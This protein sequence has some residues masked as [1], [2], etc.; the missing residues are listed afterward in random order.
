MN[1]LKLQPKQ[2]NKDILSVEI[3]KCEVVEKKMRNKAYNFLS[4]IGRESLSEVRYEDRCAYEMYLKNTGVKTK[5]QEYMCAFDKVIINSKKAKAVKALGK[6]VL[7]L[8]ERKLFLLYDLPYDKALV[9]NKTID[10]TELLWDFSFRC[11]RKIKKQIIAL[12]NYILEDYDSH[13][14]Q[15]AYLLSL[16]SLYR[17]CYEQKINDLLKLE[18]AEERRFYMY[19]SSDDTVPRYTHKIIDYCRKKLFLHSEEISWTACVWYVERFK[20]DISRINLS[21]P[22]EIISFIEITNEENRKLLQRYIKYYLS[23]S[24]YSIST[25]RHKQVILRE[26]IAYFDLYNKKINELRAEDIEQFFDYIKGKEI[27]PETVNRK[28]IEIALFYRFLVIYK[29]VDRVPFIPEYYLYKIIG[30]VHNNR[31]VNEN[32]IYDILKGLSNIPMKLRLM[33]LIL[34]CSGR[35]KN[36]ICQ[37]KGDSFFK[38]NNEF[39]VK[40][41]QP[42]MKADIIIPIPSELYKLMERYIDV[43]CILPSDY[44]FLNSMGKPYNAQTFSQQMV[45]VCN[46]IDFNSA[47]YA[48]KAHDFRHTIAT[49]LYS[50]EVS[51]QVIRD[52]LGHKS[53]EM[54]KEYI[55]YIPKKIEAETKKYH[56][57]KKKKLTDAIG[58][59]YHE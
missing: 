32:I 8:E 12:I 28:I 5:C 3:D 17:F 52:F 43:N 4:T 40:F 45:E 10:K 41:Y 29:I 53:D 50:N 31:S 25:I 39:W 6:E 42:K 59:A 35:R 38:M 2:L 16:K 23:V 14:M 18:R 55:D 30:K 58:E 57:N 24:D 15:R 47:E 44:L 26:F 21:N 19:L 49:L 48:F 33:F 20:L 37:L 36:E 56:E 46:N 9:V 7:K 51:V 34:W 22:V 54:T 1:A 11:R 27:K 13:K